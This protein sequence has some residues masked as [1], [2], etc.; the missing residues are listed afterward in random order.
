[1]MIKN[2]V[3][4]TLKR[5]N[6]RHVN[7]F[8]I[9]CISFIFISHIFCGVGLQDGTP[10]LFMI[11]LSNDFFLKEPPRLFFHFLYQLPTILLINFSSISSP[12]FLVQVFS[13]GLIWMH[14]FSFLGCYFILP[15]NKKNMLFFPL[16]SFFMG[17]L[18]CFDY[19]ISVAL[20]VC[21][22]IWLTSFI[23]YY[24]NL[25]FKIH[26]LLFFITPLPLILSHEFLGYMAWFLIF[27]CHNKKK[28]ETILFNKQLIS[29]VI[30]FLFLVSVTQIYMTFFFY[31]N[32]AIPSVIKEWV[33]FKFLFKLS[34]NN[35]NLPMFLSICTILLPFGQLLKNK[36]KH[37]LLKVGFLLIFIISAY[38]TVIVSL[39]NLE[40]FTFP[41]HY[42][43]RFYPLI[44]TMPLS[45]L[46]WLLYE[47]K[48]INIAPKM[49]VFL[50]TCIVSCLSLTFIRIDSDYKF[51]RY[52]IKFSEQLTNNCEGLVMWPEVK[53]YFQHL[54]LAY[55]LDDY[56]IFYDSLFYPRSRYIKTLVS[57]SHYMAICMD[58]NYSPPLNC[59]N[60]SY[61][62]I[63]SP[64]PSKIETLY[65]NSRFF[66]LLPI[67][68]NI[69]DNKSFCKKNILNL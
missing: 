22:Y 24:S 17:P 56:K 39:F 69:S 10:D 43:I 27:L 63:E 31:P 54:D 37:K 47:K 35:L 32:S 7:I 3:N 51:Y 68:S 2:T 12:A 52:Q 34:N 38:I 36:I 41:Y 55:V 48:K 26:R 29:F 57:P 33:Y 13:F 8:F 62:Q 30:F 58:D 18:L 6:I 66:H 49:K 20:S 9:I 67:I 46:L 60:N 40:S 28:T 16:F 42:S 15:D 11:L 64:Y 25:S 14:I 44:A 59:Y 4:E 45:V 21:S 1:M 65:E 50:F 53:K 19:S 61:K 5:I 23:I